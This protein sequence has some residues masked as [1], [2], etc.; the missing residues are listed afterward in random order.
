MEPGAVERL[1]DVG[2]FGVVEEPGVVELSMSSLP[3]LPGDRRRVVDRF[4][5]GGPATCGVQEMVFLCAAGAAAGAGLFL[6]VVV[7]VQGFALGF[8]SLSSS[9]AIQLKQIFVKNCC[10]LN[11]VKSLEF[12]K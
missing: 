12:V 4:L 11:V 10:F 6:V 8:G 7:V 9:K 1:S 2:F 3:S 5:V